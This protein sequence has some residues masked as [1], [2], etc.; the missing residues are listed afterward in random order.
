MDYEI[1]GDCIYR[2]PTKPF[3]GVIPLKEFQRINEW[4]KPMEMIDPL[5]DDFTNKSEDISN[6][7]GKFKESQNSL[8]LPMSYSCPN[9]DS[10]FDMIKYLNYLKILKCMFELPLILDKVL[11]FNLTEKNRLVDLQPIK[12]KIT[13]VIFGTTSVDEILNLNIDKILKDEGLL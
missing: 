5:E 12:A 8:N 3:G 7:I 13:E 10:D 11:L 4:S 9:V 1:R 6:I 2:D